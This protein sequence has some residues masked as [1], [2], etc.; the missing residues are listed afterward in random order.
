MIGRCPVCGEK[1]LISKAVACVAAVSGKIPRPANHMLR[2]RGAVPAKFSAFQKSRLATQTGFP[3]GFASIIA[4]S[5]KTAKGF[6]GF[7]LDPGERPR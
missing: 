5:R 2:K 3:A 6:V 1:R 4:G 7:R